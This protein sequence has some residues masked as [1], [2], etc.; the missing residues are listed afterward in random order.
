MRMAQVTPSYAAFAVMLGMAP[1]GC[2]PQMPKAAPE[3]AMSAAK[4][5]DQ[6][7]GKSLDALI[8]KLGQPHR[9]RQMDNNQST[10]VWEIEPRE[11][12]HP[13]GDGGLYGDANNPSLLRTKHLS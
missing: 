2:S 11:A 13:T 1:G 6:L 5:A 7:A 10:F 3:E 9:S 4:L 12:R 8:E